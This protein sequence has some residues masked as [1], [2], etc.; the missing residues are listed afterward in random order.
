MTSKSVL[1]DICYA[2]SNATWMST[3]VWTR[4]WA[5]L[6]E[7][8]ELAENPE[9]NEELQSTVKDFFKNSYARCFSFLLF[10]IVYMFLCAHEGR[11]SW[12]LEA[13]N[14]PRSV[15]TDYYCES[16]DREP[17]SEPLEEHCRCLPT[18]PSLL[19]LKNTLDLMSTTGTW[20]GLSL[21]IANVRKCLWKA[22]CSSMSVLTAQQR[23][24]QISK[25]A[26]LKPKQQILQNRYKFD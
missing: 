15:V 12:K 25:P 20:H 5:K 4:Q 21:A 9:R 14:S 18:E 16:P 7:L 3:L 8:N 23:L 6:G 19:P 22:R 26:S 2:T 13:L 1:T 11:Y 10:L 17:K 24:S